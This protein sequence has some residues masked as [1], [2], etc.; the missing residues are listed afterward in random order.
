MMLY[1]CGLISEDGSCAGGQASV[2]ILNR[3]AE[4][5]ESGLHYQLTKRLSELCIDETDLEPVPHDGM[6]NMIPAAY[7]K[8]PI[9]SVMSLNICKP[10][11]L[12]TFSVS[13]EN[14]INDCETIPVPSQVNFDIASVSALTVCLI[15]KGKEIVRKLDVENV[16]FHSLLAL[17]LVHGEMVQYCKIEN[18]YTMGIRCCKLH[19][20]TRRKC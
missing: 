17:F 5:L 6:T 2:E 13:C 14:F 11:F 16:G 9:Q 10:F 1:E 8:K 20:Q 12:F 4:P 15:L 3:V 18:V 7:H 19:S